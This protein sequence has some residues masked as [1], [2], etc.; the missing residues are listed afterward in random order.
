MDFN[1]LEILILVLLGL[2][3]FKETAL[4]WISQ[5]LGYKVAPSEAKREERAAD[6]NSQQVLLSN[7]ELL[8][9]HYNHET[10]PLLESIVKHQQDLRGTQLQQCTKLDLI[11]DSLQDIQRNGIRIRT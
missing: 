11:V 1:F 5:K 9:Q 10:T 8:S 2:L 6:K 4:G 7:M 3:F